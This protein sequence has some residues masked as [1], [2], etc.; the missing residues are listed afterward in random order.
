MSD[1]YLQFANSTIGKSILS[2]LG[3]PRPPKLAR[4]D[5]SNAHYLSG[6]LL[7]GT[8]TGALYST[9]IK[10]SLEATEL[11]FVDD[12]SQSC[13]LLFDA[14]GVRN[15]A[16]ATEL[17]QFFH[18][19]IAKLPRCGRVVI[20]GQQPNYID[21]VEHAIAQRGLVGFLK[22]VAK[23]I[24]RKGATANLLYLNGFG[25][26]GLAAPLRFFLSAGCASPM[27]RLLI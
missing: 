12:S 13:H 21:S 5:T 10:Q 24:G 2:I 25:H 14:S 18:N 3:L 16:Q 19:N 26:K 11:N 15:T 6:D 8:S 23:E 27:V 22:S 4:E 20:I 1:K 17:Y 7:C 9:Q